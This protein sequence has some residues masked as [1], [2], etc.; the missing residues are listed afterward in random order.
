M[1]TIQTRIY[2]IDKFL[3]KAN[4]QHT[5][6]LYLI[7]NNTETEKFEGDQNNLKSCDNRSLDTRYALNKQ[8]LDFTKII[9][10]MGANLTYIKSGTFGSTFKG[11][12][13]SET[14]QEESSFAVK[15]VAYSKKEGYGSINNVKRPENAEIC[16]LKLLSYFVIKGLTPHIL[17]PISIFNTNIQLFIDAWK[18]EDIEHF[19]KNVK[20]SFIINENGKYVEYVK[21]YIINSK[22]E[23]VMKKTNYFTNEKGDYIMIDAQNNNDKKKKLTKEDFILNE[24]E[25]EH[26]VRN[27]N[28]MLQKI[29]KEEFKYM[30]NKLN[31]PSERYGK[32]NTKYEEFVS[33]YEKG[34]F[35]KT[36]SVLITEWADRGDL[37]SFF[38]RINSEDGIQAYEVLNLLQWKCLLF[39]F[40]STLAIIQYKYPSF[41]HNDCKPNNILISKITNT[42]LRPIY[43]IGDSKYNVPNFGYC[44]YIWDFDFACIPNV[45]YNKKL[46]KKWTH[47][48]NIKPVQNRYYDIHYF[49]CT[50]VY[51]GFLPEILSSPKVPTEIKEFIEW[52]VPFEYRPLPINKKKVD[53]ERC[54]L[55]VDD[56]VHLPQDILNHKLFAE[57]KI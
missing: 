51:K 54:R 33:N 28:G 7:D 53:P 8:T 4:L 1:N 14:M 41:R 11:Y 50:L 45:I 32:I 52:V 3:N 36:V 24:D 42:C 31:N 22:G 19:A 40:I 9:E 37:A 55:L 38:R 2:N 35:N 16:M 47:E 6:P 13:L 17:L 34:L 39:Q 10:S 43:Q 49:F 48:V 5:N 56:E 21:K 57:F 18:N 23:F 27:D 29:T 26:F 46:H 25:N 44:I 12:V 15:I 30:A 20:G